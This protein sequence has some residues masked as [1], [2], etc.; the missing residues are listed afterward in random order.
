MLST[1]RSSPWVI[2]KV[3]LYAIF[4]LCILTMYTTPHMLTIN[5]LLVLS[6]GSTQLQPDILKLTSKGSIPRDT[7]HS[8]DGL[9]LGDIH[10]CPIQRTLNMQHISL[11]YLWK[12]VTEG[13]FMPSMAEGTLK[14]SGMTTILLVFQADDQHEKITNVYIGLVVR[15]IESRLYAP[16]KILD[17]VSDIE[18]NLKVACDAFKVGGDLGKRCAFCLFINN[19]GGVMLVPTDPPYCLIYPM[20]YMKDVELDHLDTCNNPAGTC[21]HHCICHA[22]LQYMNDNPTTAEHMVGAT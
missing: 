19:Y 4:L 12:P 16:E 1:T 20:S 22:T 7:L 18:V 10:F 5:F 21:L 6:D 3:S 13:A 17:F 11:D 8:Q 14:L 9:N 2:A 15:C